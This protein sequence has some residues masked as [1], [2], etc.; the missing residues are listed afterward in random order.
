MCCSRSLPP[1]FIALISGRQKSLDELKRVRVELTNE[2]TELINELGPKIWE[3]F[4]H[5]S[6]CLF[7]A[8]KVGG[9][10]MTSSII[11]GRF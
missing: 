6:M 8:V 3:D 9:I 4:D 10:D 7:L 1:L 5:V 2:L 11:S